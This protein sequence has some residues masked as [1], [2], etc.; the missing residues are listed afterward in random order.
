MHGESLRADNVSLKGNL[1]EGGSCTGQF[2]QSLPVR[3]ED[4]EQLSDYTSLTRD[5]RVGVLSGTI[6]ETR[7]LELTGIIIDDD[8]KYFCSK[9]QGVY[10][11]RV[12]P[13]QFHRC[14]Q[15]A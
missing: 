11:P 3:S 4:T 9:V 6:G 13:L 8:V 7:L 2:H 5:V 12:G 14:L 1:S 15:G 10:I